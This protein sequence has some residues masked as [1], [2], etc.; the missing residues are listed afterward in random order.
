MPEEFIPIFAQIAVIAALNI[1]MFM[2]FEHLCT[3]KYSKTVV[4]IAACIAAIIAM[5]AVNCLRIPTLNLIYGFVSFC[6]VCG[7]LYKA[8][9]IKMFLY[10]TV[11][12]L[13]I[14]VIL[15]LI[16]GSLITNKSYTDV[17]SDDEL[18]CIINL[19]DLII[20]FLI[21]R[22]TTAFFLSK[23]LRPLRIRE[24]IILLAFT[25]FEIF[26]IFSLSGRQ[27]SGTVFILIML[28]FLILNAY[29][30]YTIRKI[31]QNA[32]L[33]YELD[34]SARQSEIQL[35]YYKELDEKYQQSCRVIHDIKKHISVISNSAKSEETARYGEQINKELDTLFY[36]FSCSNKILSIVM[37]QKISAAKGKNIDVSTKIEDVDIDFMKDVDI[38]SVFA[39]LW[40]NAIEACEKTSSPFIKFE[41]K[42]VNGFLLVTVK[43]SYAGGLLTQ[44]GKILSSKPKHEG[45]GLSIIRSTAEKYNGL[46]VTEYTDAVFSAE[47]TIP[48]PNG[49]PTSTTQSAQKQTDF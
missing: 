47:L 16:I 32:K 7:L 36:G 48:I 37:S 14:S 13:F 30:T 5:S 4:Y 18:M 2:Y 15:T 41:I 39:N 19:F 12:P 6:A 38:T 17:I 23:D 25:M 46:F 49:S 21:Y 10:Y 29:I 43:N 27:T 33:K 40:D 1:I 26:V 34:L 8:N 22:I 11:L 45:L 44:K 28:G 31:A 3:R 20:M 35:A 24:M 42:K 9:S